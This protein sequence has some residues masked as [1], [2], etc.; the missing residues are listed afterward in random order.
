MRA[1]IAEHDPAVVEAPGEDADG[2]AA[3]RQEISSLQAS[4]GEP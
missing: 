4:R 3:A 1:E 2:Y